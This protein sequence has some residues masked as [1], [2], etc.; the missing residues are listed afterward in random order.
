MGMDFSKSNG[1]VGGAW[2][3]R[4][5]RGVVICHS[6]RAFS[7]IRNREDAKLVVVLWA[8]ENMRSQR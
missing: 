3:L 2:V 6:R 5:A 1:C 7:G 8:F 4:N